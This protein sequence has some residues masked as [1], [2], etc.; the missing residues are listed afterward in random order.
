LNTKKVL[1]ALENEK[2]L[3]EGEMHTGQVGC[4]TGALLVAA[5]V[6]P[7]ELRH[8]LT[9]ADVYVN[10]KNGAQLL[11]DEY[12]IDERSYEVYV[13]GVGGFLNNRARTSVGDLISLNDSFESMT[14]KERL[15]CVRAALKAGALA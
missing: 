2:G 14:Q 7:R 1:K 8:A 12:D 3:C 9:P 6:T 11:A 4:L 10:G 5:G 13:D 15:E